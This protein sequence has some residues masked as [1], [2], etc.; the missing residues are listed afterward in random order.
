MSTR[1][2]PVLGAIVAALGILAFFVAFTVYQTQQALVLQ[3]GEFKRAVD[4]PR[5]H[6]KLPW[7]RLKYYERR[8][9]DPDRKEY[10]P[11]RD[12][13]DISLFQG[14]RVGTLRGR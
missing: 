1:I 11:G 3:F 5:L 6:W 14:V 13:G 7:Q 9:L 4:E 12:R 2:L 10:P 8:V